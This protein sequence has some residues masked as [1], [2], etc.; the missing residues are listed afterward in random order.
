MPALNPNRALRRVDRGTRAP[1]AR[2]DTWSPRSPRPPAPRGLYLLDAGGRR[3]GGGDRA[4]PIRLP[5]ERARL[6]TRRFT[7]VLRAEDTSCAWAG[8]CATCHGTPTFDQE[9]RSD[10]EAPPPRG[11]GSR[12]RRA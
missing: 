10:E 7:G 11:D 5:R 9:T 3:R 4:E 8:Q 6:P 1:E 2:C 12:A